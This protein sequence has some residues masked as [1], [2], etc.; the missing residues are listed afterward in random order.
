MRTSGVLMPISSLPSPYGIGTMG[1]QAR[2]FVDFL[3]RGGQK[4]WQILPICP[5][6][7]GDSPYQSFSSF[8]GNPYFI[9]LEYLC[10]DKLLTK[11]ECESF[12][13]GSSPK[14]VDYGIMYESRYALLRKAY[15]RFMKKKPQ[16]FDEFCEKEK[17]WLDDYA[18]F[19]AL[20]DANDG[21]A[22][23]K[24]DKDLRLRKKEAMEAAKEQ[25]AEEIRFYKM[26]QYLF[27]KQWNE[28]KAYANEEGIEIIG[29]I[30]IYV[31]GDSA[32][33]WANP[34]QFYLDENLEP[35][36]V[37]G[38]PPD[39]FSDD[40]Q[41]WG[42][43]LFRW[44]VM[45]KDGYTWWTRRIKAM[46]ELYDIIRIDHFR[47]FDSYYAI[48][49][50]DDTAKNGQWKEGP[51]MDLFTEL[52]KKLGKLPIIV[53]D[54]GFLTPSVH[55]LLKD[56]GFPGMKVIQFAFDS[57]EE[58][59]YLPHTYTNHCVV[60]TGTHDNDTVM[61]WMKTAPKASVKYAKEYLNLTK[62]EGYNWGMMRAAWS[63]V[64][65]MAIVPM[66]DILGLGSEAR[67]N[68]P[69][70]LGENWKWRATPEQIDTKIAKKLHH[71][72]QM[73]GRVNKELRVEKEAEAKK[74]AEAST[75]K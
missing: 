45:K 52:E 37:A 1:K 2:K 46:S 44:D 40:G 63:S 35:I 3:V 26:L 70:T 75:E 60:Y 30:P 29:D 62:E 14:Y 59:D 27:Y 5:T 57:R 43:P 23:S 13:W 21:Q 36:E 24:W 12:K 28:L 65:D 20:K 69:S 33:V 74:A 18:L 19:M 73:Y 22:W 68:T 11:K 47:G 8:A 42:N 9:D 56:S 7:Y 38:C 55:K 71:Y 32:D 72:M 53:E 54:L 58:S 10:K 48:P 25:Y 64:A 51:G 17:Q 16:D 4:Y 50:K 61:G 41:L 31:A 34:D 39:A 49:A 6:S 15:V 67:I 66:Q